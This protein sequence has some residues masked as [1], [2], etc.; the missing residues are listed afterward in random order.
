MTRDI[1]T[2][3]VFNP[4]QAMVDTIHHVL[5]E[6]QKETIGKNSSP[7]IRI[8]GGSRKRGFTFVKCEVCQG[9]VLCG[10]Q[11]SS[12]LDMMVLVE[13]ER[14]G[15]SQVTIEDKKDMD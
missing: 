10:R 9:A 4:E 12:T 6:E 1:I 11:R 15:G 8:P 2:A 13:I 3:K 5:W 14:L 7:V